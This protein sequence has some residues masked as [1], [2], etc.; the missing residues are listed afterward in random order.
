LVDFEGTLWIRDLTRAGLVGMA[1]EEYEFPEEVAN[2]LGKLADD[3]RNEVWLLSGLRVDGVLERFR[4]K[5]PKVGIVAENGC[6]IKTRAVGSYNG[7]WINMVSNFNLTWKSACLEILNYFTERT[8]GSFIEERQASMVWRFWMAGIPGDTADRQW[9]QR[10]A[11]EAQ[12]HIF[13][14][15]GERYG[16]RIIPGKNSF[17]VLPNNVSRSTAVGAI[18]HPGGPARSLL[19][20]NGHHQ[21]VGRSN[22][23]SSLNNGSNIN[24]GG[25][26]GGGVWSGSSTPRDE[27]AFSFNLGSSDSSSSGGSGNGAEDVDF[28][29][30]V[31]S[32]EKMLR[33]LNE[34]DVSETVST[35][36]KG[37]DGKWKLESEETVKTLGMFAGVV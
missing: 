26:G 1:K 24:S 16:L 10:Q 3:S 36:G 8:P 34:F 20:R 37:T 12:N 28:L 29:L 22:S 19:T 14:S 6:F 35:S 11:A 15:L 33:R 27:H 32:D 30:A 21:R 2:V 4:E 18:L 17:L 25:G 13:D 31:S 23:I 9:A 7:E 5:V